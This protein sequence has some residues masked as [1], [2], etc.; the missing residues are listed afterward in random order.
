MIILLFGLGK[1]KYC[2]QLLQFELRKVL[3]GG[4]FL[5]ALT[6]LPTARKYDWLYSWDVLLSY[7]Y[8]GKEHLRWGRAIFGS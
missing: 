4:I 7:S 6:F 8:R 1:R 2:M 3:N 5:E